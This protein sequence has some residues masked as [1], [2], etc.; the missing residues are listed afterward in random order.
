MSED[1]ENSTLDLDNL[2]DN[3]DS[4]YYD[5]IVSQSANTE[6]ARQHFDKVIER[7]WLTVIIPYMAQGGIL[8]LLDP[9]AG[10]SLFYKMIL[11]NSEVHEEANIL[12]Q[13][14]ENE[15]LLLENGLINAFDGEVQ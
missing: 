1:T 4:T 10:F 2:E 14:T 8:D 11:E 5:E 15:I 13:H 3:T 7:I 6:L 12:D 9:D